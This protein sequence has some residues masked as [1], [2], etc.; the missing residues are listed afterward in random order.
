V[1]YAMDALAAL[2]APAVPR[3]IDA[4][5][6][7]KFR[8]NIVYILGQIGPAAAP[9]TEA[10]A[11]LLDDRKPAVA[12]E[13]AMALA[14][15]GPGAK[16]AVAELAKVLEKG[17]ESNAHAVIFALGKIGPDAAAADAALLAAL[18]SKDDSLA[19]V[20]AWALS[21]IHPASAEMAAKTVPVLVAGLAAT[22]PEHRK[23]AAEALGGLGPL[24]KDAVAALQKAA[25]DEDKDVRDA[26]AQA[27]KAIGSPDAGT[28]GT[29]AVTPTPKM[30][31]IEPGGAA[32]AVQGALP[33][34]MGSKI[35]ARL[36]KGTELKVIEIRG[37][38]IGVRATVEGQPRT[39]W[40]PRSEVAP[41]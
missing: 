28:P 33:L 26:A 21:Q 38:W 3:L 31:A 15:I 11:K 25:S 4:L 30:K 32:V 36:P 39:G 37:D 41:Q 22:L 24:A 19:L 27:L 20:S 16:G 23:G 7:E 29:G 9:A 40:V 10:L 35:V 6:H 1:Q 34:R 12:S 13:A 2:G 8:G 17:D 14:K 18:K 5:K